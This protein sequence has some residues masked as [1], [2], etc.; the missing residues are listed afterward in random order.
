MKIFKKICSAFES[1]ID[2]MIFVVA[3]AMMIIGILQILFRYV[4]SSALSWSEETIRYLHVWLVT[5]GGT[6]CFYHGSF[7]TINLVSDKIE[8]K[9]K[10]GGK[11]LAIMRFV[12]PVIFYG[13][14]LIEGV[15]VCDAYVVKKTAVTQI[16]MSLV[17]LCIPLTGVFGL[18]FSAAKIPELIKKLK[19]ETE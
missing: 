3:V 13:L 12:I 5:I 8:A 2:V 1:S 19:G 14:M 18:C 9:F 11:L 6:V 15:Q 7:A 16:S 10:L 4:F 17:Y